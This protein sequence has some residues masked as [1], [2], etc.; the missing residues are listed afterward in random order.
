MIS[1]EQI[2][3]RAACADGQMPILIYLL[4]HV[5]LNPLLPDP[6]DNKCPLQVAVSNGHTDIILMIFH[7]LRMRQMTCVIEELR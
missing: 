6:Y 2:Q 3:L 4:F 7:Y 5:H 1:M